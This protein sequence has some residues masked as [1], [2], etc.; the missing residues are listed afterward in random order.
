[1]RALLFYRW[2]RMRFNVSHLVK[3]PIGTQGVLHLDS[4][5]ISLDRDL[6]LHSLHGEIILTRSTDCLLAEGQL[7]TTLDSE[8]VRCLVSFPLSL[9][10]QLDDLAFALPHI[11]PQDNQYRISQDGW[12]NVDLALREQVFLDIP[13]YTL[14]RPDCRGLC[15]MCG[16]DLNNG[17][18]DCKELKIDPRLA[19]LR[20][21]L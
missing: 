1:L 17:S 15:S 14:C 2:S 11:S 6:Y 12:V 13:Q 7:D 3:A 18:C 9:T 20:D 4:G 8:C 10:I 5:A 16:Q 21:L 19:A